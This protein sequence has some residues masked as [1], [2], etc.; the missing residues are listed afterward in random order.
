MKCVFC[1][2]GEVKSKLANAEGGLV[3]L[4]VCKGDEVFLDESFGRP[5]TIVQL[6]GLQ[7][8]AR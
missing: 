5:F 4:P 6:A 7:K 2:F 8:A 3:R 1:G